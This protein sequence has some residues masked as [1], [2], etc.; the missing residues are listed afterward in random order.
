MPS[1]TPPGPDELMRILTRI[2]T[3][4]TALANE[5]KEDRKEAAR[6]YVRQD[7]YLRAEQLTNSLIADTRADI[8]V[9]D[10]KVEIDRKERDQQR[11]DDVVARRQIWLAL[12]GISVTL[13][14]GIAGL[15]IQVVR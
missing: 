15:I 14:L 3:A 12:G 5:I 8:A 1:L 9:V 4:L 10:S 6:L 13:L 11:K 2:E 7:V